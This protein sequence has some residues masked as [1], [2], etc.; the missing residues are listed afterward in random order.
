MP[1]RF[2]IFMAD[3]KTTRPPQCRWSTLF[4]F[5]Y[6]RDN[7]KPAAASRSITSA[8]RG[9]SSWSSKS[10]VGAITI[11]ASP[12]FKIAKIAIS[13]MNA[14]DLPEPKPQKAALCI[15]KLWS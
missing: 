13:Q 10:N 8:Q 11:P 15:R 6:R 4:V 14:S 2:S 7:G 1:R 12:G 9:N 5:A 3:R